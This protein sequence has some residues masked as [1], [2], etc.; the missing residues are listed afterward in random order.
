MKNKELFDKTVS[1]LVKAYFEGTL[2]HGECPACAVG[3]IIAANR[4][5]VIV[6][7]PAKKGFRW[8][9]HW[10][11]VKGDE[12]AVNWDQSCSLGEAIPSKNFGRT[13]NQIKATGYPLKD[14]ASIEEAFEKFTGFDDSKYSDLD[15]FKGLMAVVDVLQEIHECTDEE[16]DEAKALFVKQ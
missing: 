11:D 6:N 16:R 4:G 7:S 9:V 14:V 12:V 15:G 1:I 3:N 13:R 10:E 5:Y 8:R 2:L